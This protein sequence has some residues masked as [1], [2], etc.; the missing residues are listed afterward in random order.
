M[1]ERKNDWRRR[2]LKKREGKIE[3]KEEVESN[4]SRKT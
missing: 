1:T 3:E 4:S 2:V